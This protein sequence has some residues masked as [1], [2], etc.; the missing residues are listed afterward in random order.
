MEN[1]R[2]DDKYAN[3]FN[4]KLKLILLFICPPAWTMMQ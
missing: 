1:R 4:L 2:V 3:K